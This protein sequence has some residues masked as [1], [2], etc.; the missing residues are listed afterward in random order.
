MNKHA[1]LI[2]AHNKLN[3]LTNLIECIDYDSNDI[4]IHLDK[5]WKL[6]KEEIQRIE[7]TA[8]KSDIYF[9]KNRINVK[10]G[11]Y[12][13][14]EC[15]MSLLKESLKKGYQY[16]HLM[17]GVD[18]PL[19]KQ[20]EIH[21][22]FAQNAGKEF[23]HYDSNKI[24]STAYE[25]VSKYHF[26]VS[27]SN[28]LIGKGVNQ[29]SRVLQKGI[30]RIGKYDIEFQKGANWFSITN[31][32]AQYV[33]NKEKNIKK[34]FKYSR[35]GDEMFLQTI[36]INSRFKDKLVQNNYCDNYGTIQYCIDWK[37]GNPYTYRL[38]DYD[39]LVESGMC[40]ARKFDCSVDNEIIKAIKQ[41]V[42]ED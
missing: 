2:M 4:Y 22:F 35:C 19:K 33:L 30:D 26:F 20:V 11:T 36:V 7:K 8:K 16:Y 37:R 3:E 41:K 23:V 14:I 1:Y 39:Y 28:G 15:E 18:M 40:F 24:D 10:W 42:V 5:K 13:Q 34:I 38:D 31:D 32:L 9:I 29:I 17:S 27:R 21:N 6:S 12:T 25:R